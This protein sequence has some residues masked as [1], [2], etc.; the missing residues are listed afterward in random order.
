MKTIDKVL[1]WLI[2]L[3][4]ASVVAL[5]IARRQA[6]GKNAEL[7]K[8]AMGDVKA[9]FPE[10]A[11]ARCIDTSYFEVID[12]G[13]QV[14][15]TVML[16][17]PYSDKVRGYA[18]KTP[19]QIAFDNDDKILDVRLL[20][21]NETPRFIDRVEKAGL[22]ETWNGLSVEEALDADVD[23]VSGAT[24]SSEGIINSM[25]A[26]LSAA[27]RQQA[28][29]ERKTGD[30]MA[31]VAILLVVALALVCFFIPQQTKTLRLVTLLLS[32]AILGFWRNA[33]MSLYLF[34]SWLSNGIPLATQWVLVALAAM[35]FL[36]P[37]FTGRAFYCGY[38][39]PLGALQELA[40][41]ACK[42]K[43][44]VSSSCATIL[45]IVRKLF[46]L[47]ILVLTALGVIGNLVFFEPFSV[48]SV[49]SLTVFSLVFAAVVLAVSLFVNRAWCRFLCP[50]GLLFE[51]IRRLSFRKA[52]VPAREAKA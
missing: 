49:R 42:R 18:G 1:G 6:S 20:R 31:N 15:G 48:F 22:L 10:A 33:T 44:R 28:A 16:S 5:Q 29:K 39:C 23:A 34:Y 7:P 47:T 43:V 50:T 45:L 2:L 41:M 21:N 37:L 13:D 40:G 36:L 46:L 12:A 51:L 38:L 11:N 35:A 8:I 4:L 52:R 25:K 32:V 27:S 14:L 17:S 9:V 24:Y 26:R 19:L 3:A 30:T